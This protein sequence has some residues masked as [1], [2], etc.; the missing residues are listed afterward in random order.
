MIGV[1]S[2]GTSCMIDTIREAGRFTHHGRLAARN[3][4]PAAEYHLGAA[5][6]PACSV[7]TFLGS[8]AFCVRRLAIPGI[9]RI[10]RAPA[11]HSWDRTHPACAGSPFLGSHASCVRRLAIPGIA[12]I[13]RAP[14]PGPRKNHL[15]L[16]QSALDIIDRVFRIVGGGDAN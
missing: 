12:R 1:S 14:P 4:E 16:V 5:T 13:L 7:L 15:P 2:A 9:A 10:L 6:H 11:R 8:H 3:G